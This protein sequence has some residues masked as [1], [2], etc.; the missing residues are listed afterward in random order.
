M[1]EVIQLS[2]LHQFKKSGK[3]LILDVQTSRVFAVDE[4]AYDI[5]RNS[6][7]KT[8]SEVVS[9]LRDS[10]PA[11]DIDG[12]YGELKAARLISEEPFDFKEPT[13]E[14]SEYEIRNM[15]LI[16]SQ[17]CNMR[18][19]YCFADRGAFRGKRGFMSQE[20]GKK[21]IDFLIEKSGKGKRLGVVFFGG[22]PLLNTTGLK[23]LVSYGNEKSKAAEKDM[24]YSVSTNGTLLNEEL[25]EYFNNE[26][27]NVQISIDGDA[28]TQNV[29]RPFK[30][31]K[32][33]YDSVEE[34][35]VQFIGKTKQGQTSAR[36]TITSNSVQ[37]AFENVLHILS[38]GFY[39][40]HTETAEGT[41]GKGFLTS[42][43]Y[44]VL[45]TKIDSIAE[46]LKEKIS[47]NKYFGYSN[48]V[49]VLMI[50]NANAKNFFSCGSGRGYVAVGTNGDIFPCHR[51]V[52]SSYKM[53]N[54]MDGTFDRYWEKEI[55]LKTNVFARVPC[56]SC[57][58]RF[59]C[60][61]DC[62]A[63]S[64][65]YYKDLITPN[66]MR[67]DLIKYVLETAIMVYSSIPKTKKAE[68]E[69]TYHFYKRQKK[70]IP[71]ERQI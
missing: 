62:I 51:F 23:E 65:D 24:R 58:A 37:R 25:I 18:C 55:H 11:E 4:L 9:I 7:L 12:A 59:L 19:I 10:Y 71:T 70:E 1:E 68:V 50:L 39:S 20:V 29:N 49:K 57:W 38:M 14:Y 30:R 44:K 69:N 2:E 40:V 17:D 8:K 67:C 63:I 16:L 31:N 34:K 60:G 54:V 48:I 27:I 52:N 45:E 46:E 15:D 35:S 13:T 6:N 21:A 64:E 42:D 26:K 5:V 47:Q 28:E 41:M 33:S 32:P 22:K 53:G 43:D 61:G 66:P 56:N 36:T 3:N